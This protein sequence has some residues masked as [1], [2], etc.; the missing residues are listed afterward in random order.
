M[1]RLIAIA[2]TGAA[3]AA[4][5]GPRGPLGR[6]WAPAPAAPHVHGALLAGFVTENMVENVAFGLGLAILLLGR[7]WYA[8]RIPN[9]AKAT[10]GWL[11]TVWLFASWMPHAALH[12]HVGMQPAALLP[13]EWVFH[14]GAI[15]AIA[16]LLWALFNPL[17]QTNATD[18]HTTATSSRTAVEHHV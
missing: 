5:A 16:A 14:A 13:I 1:R 9:T 12:L 10:T 3:L 18:G 6:F 17:G 15:V 8:A 4:L 11:A 7:R 2:I